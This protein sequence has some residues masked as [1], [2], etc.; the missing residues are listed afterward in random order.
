MS[1]LFGKNAVVDLQGNAV[2][3]AGTEDICA[4]TFDGNKR[5][6]S[7]AVPGTV[8]QIGDRAFADCV[9][10]E[11]VELAEG[12]EAIGQN[13][14][15]GCSGLKELALP[16]SIKEIDGWAFYHFT[17]LQTPVYNRSGTVLYGYPCSAEERI[18]TLPARVER[19]N[20]A[21]FLWN[22][23]LEE[24][25]LPEGLERI[26]SKTFVN[27]GLRRII[28]PESVKRIEERAFWS[29]PALTEVVVLG[30]HTQIS[31]GAFFQ[32]SPNLEIVT[33][34]SVS[35]DEK[36][37]LLGIPF[38]VPIKVEY[39]DGE[40]LKDS[41]FQQLATQ[42]ALGDSDAM[43][44]M[45]EYFLGLGDHPF[46]TAAA[47][48]WRYRACRNGHADAKQWLNTWR[49]EHPGKRLASVLN[50]SMTGTACGKTL[51]NTGFLFFDPAREYSISKTDKGDILEVSSWC[52]GAAPDADGF[53]REE[54]YDW[55][56]LDG[57][58]NPLPGV[59]M[60]SG[61]SLR[62]K[63][64][65]ETLFQDRLEKAAAWIAMQR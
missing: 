10:L 29:C 31:D 3:P 62:D 56:Y 20:A 58:L 60:I 43:W 19:I 38:L 33:N 14:F 42:C 53:G 39:P 17:G 63:R 50:E 7:I 4:R 49:E 2:V 65:N 55:W 35:V 32:C 51:H 54:Y 64:A 25:V 34:R 23:H 6:K 41:R 30:E 16:N 28:L 27:C 21:A 40:H 45:G 18:F 26:V 37:R 59:E 12:I 57:N 13:A 44:A 47:N 8:R 48:F 24:V 9:N 61:Y 46:Y 1:K 22:S 15:T 11:K 52:G 5:L 36:L